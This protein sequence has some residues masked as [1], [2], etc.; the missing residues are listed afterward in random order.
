V[1]V[2]AWREQGAIWEASLNPNKYKKEPRVVSVVLASL[3]LLITSWCGV[4]LAGERLR[5]ENV[6]V[7]Q[8]QGQYLLDVDTMVRM[9]SGPA[10]ALRKGVSL[11]FNLEVALIRQRTWWPD[12]TVR[13]ITKRYRLFYFELTRHYRVTEISSG[14]SHN[15]RTLDEALIQLGK[16]RSFSLIEASKVKT[17]KR[18]RL[19][20]E[21]ALDISDLPAPL[22]LQAYTTRRWRLRSEPMQWPLD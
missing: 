12:S 15:F 14:E 3:L 8:A 19:E 1:D 9:R 16:I 4:L 7:Y 11:Y 21:M 6:R 13:S 2:S 20:M 5:F 10:E 22:Q 18:Y 17:P